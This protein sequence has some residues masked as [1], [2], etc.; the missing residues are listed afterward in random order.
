[1]S[2]TVNENLINAAD[3]FK[4]LHEN[5]ATFVMPCAWDAFSAMLLERT[6]FQCL[7]TTSG[8][9]N[10]VR[11]RKDYVYSTPS[12]EMLSIYGAIAEATDLPVSGDLENGYG[13]SPESVAN[14]ILGSIE[15]GMVGGSIEDQGV[16]PTDEQCSNGELID[17]DL[18]VQRIREARKAADT[19]NFSYTLTA[20]CEVYYTNSSDPYGEAVKRLNAYREAGADCLFVPGLNDLKG[21]EQLVRD[22]D[23]PIS[24]GMGATPEPLSINI[25]E[26][27]GIRRVSTGGG[28][29]RATFALLDNAAKEIL[30]D[31]TFGYL[32]NVLSEAAIHQ[33]LDRADIP[34]VTKLT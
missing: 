30:H 2:T 18:A 33:I 31:G 21:L 5:S 19:A 3:R 24:F 10:W 13:T 27:I 20:R 4:A 34:T 15:A 1:M 8:G 28:L 12:D 6:G 16:V 11:G 26:D 17:F 14:T 23:G 29:A 9:A 22:V 32:H 7:G 25:L